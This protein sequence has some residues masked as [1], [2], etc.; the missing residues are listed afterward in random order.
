MSCG[1]IIILPQ[2]VVSDNMAYW[3]VFIEVSKE[4][5]IRSVG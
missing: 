2:V 1:K 4:E 5:G 3:A